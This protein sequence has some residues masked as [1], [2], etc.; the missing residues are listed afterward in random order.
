M[1]PNSRYACRGDEMDLDGAY[2]GTTFPH[3]FLIQFP[4]LWP[5]KPVKVEAYVPRV[6]GFRVRLPDRGSAI[7][8]DEE[9]EDQ[10]QTSATH[11]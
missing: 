1:L 6:F 5:P 8:D 9:M 4:E 10:T 7:E 11:K 3:L 2:F